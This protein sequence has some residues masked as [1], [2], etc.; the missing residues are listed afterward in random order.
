MELLCVEDS[1]TDNS[2]D[3]LNKHAILDKRIRVFKKMNEIISVESA[4]YSLKF[5]KG[6]CFVYSSQDDLVSND[7]LEKNIKK[8]LKKNADYVLP[9]MK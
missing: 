3:I 8:S 6:E 7:L 5:A 9:I 1:S 4:N 2:Y